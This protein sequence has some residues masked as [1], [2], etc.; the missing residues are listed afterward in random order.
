MMKNPEILGNSGKFWGQYTWEI[1][2]LGTVYIII[3]NESQEV[4]IPGTVYIINDNESQEGSINE[5]S[6][7]PE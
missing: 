3:D 6:G 1:L 4:Q 5:W 7:L 2:I